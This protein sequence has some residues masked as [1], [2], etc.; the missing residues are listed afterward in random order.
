[1]STLKARIASAFRQREL[2]FWLGCLVILLVS[3]LLF[4]YGYCWGWWGRNSL[5]LQYH[6]QC[7]CPIASEQTR[8][9]EEVEVIVSACRHN[10]SKLS[11]SGQFLLVNE[12]KSALLIYLYDLQTMEKVPAQSISSFL[13]DE[14]G[15]VES[16]LE[17]DIIDLSTGKQYPIRT[18]RYWQTNAYINGEPNIELLIASLHQAE[19]VILT[20]NYSTVFVLMPNFLTM[21][22]HNF[23]FSLF[24]FPE[25]GPRRV[26][27]FLQENN[28]VYR[29][30][31][32]RFPHEVL[33]PDGRLLARDDGIYL[34]ETDQMI[35]K[36]PVSF[37]SGW[38]YDGRGVIYA[39]S[40]RCLLTLGLPF[41][42][43]TWCEIEVPQPVLLLKVPE[44]YLVPQEVP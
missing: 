22:E 10:Y 32:P 44:E 26:E 8:Y 4:Y 24:D 40:H 15:F 33:S 41:G 20:P 27:Q 3:P 25:W 29:T 17:D 31:L 35:V 34:V 2:E 16:G 19:Q 7:D 42:D 28:I 1:M 13:T 43:D 9:A 21:P 18:Y 6:F 12:G 14:L 39:A 23:T 11:P 36:A 38:T 37:V 5:L 30:I